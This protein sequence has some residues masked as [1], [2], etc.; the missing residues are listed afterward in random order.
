MINSNYIFSNTKVE[1]GWENSTFDDE[2]KAMFLQLSKTTISN[3]S[4]HFE[5]E[6]LRNLDVNIEKIHIQ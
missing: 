3:L 4:Q 2:F 5:D 1:D 6:K